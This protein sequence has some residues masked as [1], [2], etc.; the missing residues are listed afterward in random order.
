MNLGSVKVLIEIVLNL[1]SNLGSIASLIIL[2]FS[3][4][5]RWTFHVFKSNPVSSSDVLHFSVDRSCTSLVNCFPNVFF[6]FDVIVSG[7]CFLILKLL[8]ASL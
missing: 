6:L 4:Y 8:S 5:K 7:I 2:K 3:I 1:W